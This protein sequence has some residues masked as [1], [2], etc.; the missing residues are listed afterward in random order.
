MVSTESQPPVTAAPVLLVHADAEMRRLVTEAFK[1]PDFKVIVAE[2]VDSACSRIPIIHPVAV[3]VGV[4]PA[5][6]HADLAA[7]ARRLDPPAVLIVLAP[8]ESQERLAAFLRAGAD[9]C[10]S[11]QAPPAA[12]ALKVQALL[13]VMRR[14]A[15]RW[16]ER[17]VQGGLV[18][19]EGTLPL[20]KHCEVQKLSGKLTVRSG[21]T[22]VWGEFLGGELVR[23]GGSETAPGVDHLSALLDIRE[24]SYVIQQRPLSPLGASSRP[25]PETLFHAQVPVAQEIAEAPE[26]HE[27]T[28][29]VVPEG[30]QTR[31][32]VPAQQVAYEIET[33]GEN[34]PNYTVTTVV[35]RDGKVVQ[36]AQAAWSYPLRRHEDWSAARQQIEGQH[37]RLTTSIRELASQN[38]P[39][40][41]PQAQG[42]DATLLS[43]AIHF[44]VEQGWAHLGT[45]IAI[46]LLR[47]THASVAERYAIL[48]RFRVNDNAHV[49][50]DLAE[51]AILPAEAVEAVAEWLAE[52][53]ALAARVVPDAADV[54][55]R[56]ATMLMGNALDRV[57][58]YTAFDQARRSAA[59]RG[60]A[61]A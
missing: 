57:G 2:R 54:Q 30:C 16:R 12:L 7:A 41:A 5:S 1:P 45:T 24:G 44:L 23:A 56:Q 42:V 48:R 10:L 32:E 38:P 17:Q 49:N 8:S 51:G 50:V 13:R 61:T 29:V 39:P 53:L 9:D 33:Q 47:R 37:A 36:R 34:R 28:E 26:T 21:R 43:W 52:F 4:E 55:V 31:V 60:P 3:L 19:R 59:K 46:N 20:V 35:K 15:A 11:L 14:G 18:G 22:V 6:A 25:A 40:T 27:E 58:F